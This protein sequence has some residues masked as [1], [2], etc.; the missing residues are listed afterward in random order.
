MQDTILIIP[1]YPYCIEEVFEDVPLDDCWFA[2]PQLLLTCYL[3]P[4]GGRPPK[5]PTY[6][7]GPDDLRYRLVFFST[8]EELKLPIWGPM[9]SAG[10][11]KLYEPFPTPCLSS[12]KQAPYNIVYNGHNIVNFCAKLQETP[13]L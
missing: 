13:S 1:P 12:E 3:R 5:N 4:K 8:F 6:S 9:E 10:V 2:R 7:C 11:T